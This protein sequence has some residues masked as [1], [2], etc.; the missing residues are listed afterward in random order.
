S[1]IRLA[2]PLQVFAIDLSDKWR[3]SHIRDQG[4]QWQAA[5]RDVARPRSPRT[6]TFSYT[7]PGRIGNDMKALTM[8]RP[9][10]GRA[11]AAHGPAMWAAMIEPPVC[12]TPAI[13][14]GLATTEGHRVCSRRMWTSYQWRFVRR[15]P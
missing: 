14:R 8:L 4:R 11:C 5:S 2:E 6:I 13:G 9:V 10:A 3:S 1:V 15:Q 12:D 7:W